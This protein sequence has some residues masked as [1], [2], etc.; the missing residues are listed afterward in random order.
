MK[1]IIVNKKLWFWLLCKK[2]LFY[3]LLW[4][5]YTFNLVNFPTFFKEKLIKVLSLCPNTAVELNG[6]R[7]LC[8]NILRLS[9]ED[10]LRNPEEFVSLKWLSATRSHLFWGHYSWHGADSCF[11]PSISNFSPYNVMK[12]GLLGWGFRNYLKIS[13]L[14]S[15]II[16]ALQKQANIFKIWNILG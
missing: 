3:V 12:R 10:F 16:Y 8:S 14:S 15:K 11:H 9:Q 4:T 1:F 5:F 6:D 2:I 7:F 13:L